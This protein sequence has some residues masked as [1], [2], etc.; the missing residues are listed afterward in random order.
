MQRAI[1]GFTLGIVVTAACVSALWMASRPAQATDAHA[2]SVVALKAKLGELERKLPAPELGQQM[3]ELQIRHDRLWWAGQAGNWNLAY[4]MVSELGETLRGIEQTNGDAAE[5]QPA[6]LSEVM[7][8]IMDPAIRGVQD[9]LAKQDKAAFAKS[10]DRLSA[11][12]NACHA[13]AGVQFLHIQRPQTPLLDNL[14]YAP[15]AKP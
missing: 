8:A 7:P 12:C 10:F 13:T 9:A 1:I 15:E 11:A 5:L 3:L 2:E 6:K 14:R 4:Y